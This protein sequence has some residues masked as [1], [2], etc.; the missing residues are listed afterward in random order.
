MKFYYHTF[1]F[2]IF[3]YFNCYQCEDFTLF[4]IN[5]IFFYRFGNEEKHPYVKQIEVLQSL[6]SKD[7]QDFED[8]IANKLGNSVAA[9][10]SVPTAIYCFLR[11]QKPVEFIKVILMSYNPYTI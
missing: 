5:F 9:L 6:L 1:Y 10:Y 3:K 8:E 4:L 2:V 11:G 7:P